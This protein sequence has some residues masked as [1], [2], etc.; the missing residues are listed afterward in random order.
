M[1]VDVTYLFRH[2]DKFLQAQKSL[3][4]RV[5]AAQEDVNRQKEEDCRPEA[6]DRSRPTWHAR[7]AQLEKK[8]DA[9]QAKLQIQVN[10]QK[11][12]FLREEYKLYKAS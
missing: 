6:A 8:L 7:V 4:A 5:T 1:V 12:E 11:R 2:C 3:K 9:L 10:A